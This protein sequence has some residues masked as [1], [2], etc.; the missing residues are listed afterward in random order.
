MNKIT[1][2][3]LCLPILLTSLALAVSSCK[4]DEKTP[5]RD[6]FFA[7]YTVAQDCSGQTNTY[8][9]T[10]ATS[11]VSEDAVVINNFYSNAN[12]DL[13]ATISGDN[14]TIPSQTINSVTFT[15]TGTISG[16]I[17]TLNYTLANGAASVACT[18]ICTKK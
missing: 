9:I 6:K 5:D 14:I 17:L 4:K 1:S 18:A 11:A 15:G 10:I 16:E 8:E 3:W 12:F 2:K 7:T 13:N